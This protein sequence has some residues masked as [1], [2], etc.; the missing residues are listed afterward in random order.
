MRVP[1]HQTK[2]FLV[3]PWS[4]EAKEKE[5]QRILKTKPW[6]YSKSQGGQRRSAM[7]AVKHGCRSKAFRTLSSQLSAL[8]NIRLEVAGLLRSEGET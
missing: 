5:R 7:N 6:Q 1:Y 4:K 8:N 3:M 2:R